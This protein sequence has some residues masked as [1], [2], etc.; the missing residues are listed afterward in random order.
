[1]FLGKG[2]GIWDHL[3]HYNNE[4]ILDGSTGDIACDS[5]HKY[6][7][8]V[9]LLKEMGVDFYRFSISWP[10]ILPSGLSSKINPAGIQYYN[11]LID[12]LLANGIQPM[13]T[14]YHWN[15]PQYLQDVGGWVNPK[16]VKYFTEFARI[17]FENFG[18]RV[19]TWFTINEP[20][21]I[22]SFGYGDV[23]KAPALNASGIGD[24]QCAYN[25]LKA[26]ASVYHLYD[27]KFRPSQKGIK[28]HNW[29]RKNILNRYLYSR[30]NRHSSR[31]VLSCCSN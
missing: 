31:H 7:E 6:L 9:A 5:Y 2:E 28:A 17:A 18:D 13:I 22:C 16:I 25:V 30:E 23:K 24:Y 14:L 27:Q 10:R 15:L 19:K 4:L 11:N 12:A 3:V 26:H 29:T 8:D 21:I 1:M 20:R